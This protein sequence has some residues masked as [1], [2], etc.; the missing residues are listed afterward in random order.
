MR[1]ALLSTILLLA[2][3][4]LAQHPQ[5]YAGHQA[6]EIKALSSEEVKQYQSGAG[7]SFALAAEL[8]R[9]PGPL[10]SLELA[11]RL[12]LTGPQR[13]ALQLLMDNHK[14]EAR[15]IG[16]RVVESERELDALFRSGTV[17]A[18]ELRAKVAATGALR[19]DYRLSH[20]ETHRRTRELLTPEQVALYD[21][22][23][24]YGDV[25]NGHKSLR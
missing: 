13:T 9:Y 24:G 12:K 5:S 4:A 2:A 21:R 10:H 7:M 6:R 22:L 14:A 8:N 16:A 1:W 19:A 11:D 23:R 18:G 20:L 17:T 15:A 25:H 3:P